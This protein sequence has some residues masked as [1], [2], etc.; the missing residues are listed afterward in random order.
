MEFIIKR[1]TLIS[2]LF[3]AITML[4]Y[5]SYQQL[6]MELMPVP[7][8][9][10]L[11]ITVT[12]NNV[13]LDPEYIESQAIIPIEGAIGTLENIE[14]IN[15]S[16]SKRNSSI[17]ISYKAGTDMNLAYLK[18]EQEMNDTRSSLPDEFNVIVSKSN[19]TSLSNMFMN[20]LI[21]G[22]GDEDQIRNITD[23]DI[24]PELE[25][26]DGIASVNVFGGSSKSVEIV[27]DPD[28]AE[29]YQLTPNRIINKLRSGQLDRVS[30]GEA[31]KG[32]TR[33][34]VNVSSEFTEISNI[35]DIVIS[36]EGPVLLKDI[37]EISF[38]TKDPTSY[39]RVNGKESITIIL[40]NDTEVNE[41]DLSHRTREAIEKINAENAERG[42]EVI[43]QSD[44]AETM[45]NNINQIIELAVIGGIL[46]IIILWYFLQNLTLVL[47]VS[48]AI[49][50]S[51]YAA[52]NMF[53]AFGITINSLSLVGMALA[54]GMLIDNS[55]VVL[56]NIYR[57]VSTGKSIKDSVL[58]GVQEVWKSIFA[59]TLTTVAVFVPF[60]YSENIVTRL[61]SKQ[62]GVSIISTLLFSLLAA[63]LLIPMMTSVILNRTKSNEIKGFQ[64][65]SIRSR[66][67][68]IYLL[69]LKS[70]MRKPAQ[71]IIGA[72][73][74]FFITL[75]LCLTNTTNALQEV[76]TDQIDL[77]VTMPTGSTLDKCDEL[78]VQLEE[79]L[80][81]IEEKETVTSKVEEET[82][83]LSLK[84]AEN[85]ESIAD[86][87]MTD[88]RQQMKS[89][90][91]QYKDAA[92]IDFEASESSDR[93][94][95]GGGGQAN[96]S[97][98][99]ERMLGMG[100]SEER[101][102]I[103]GDDYYLL[104]QVCEDLEYYLEEMDEISRVRSDMSSNQPE[105]HLDFSGEML[106]K[107][108]IT[109][110]SISSEL[111]SFDKEIESGFNFKT[112]NEEYE[113][114]IRMDTVTE[115]D[116]N[117]M[118][119]LQK[120][121]VENTESATYELQSISSIFK[122]SGISRI[123]RTNLQ[124][125][126]EIT[127][128]FSDDINDS[129]ELLE[130]S[131]LAI[132]ELV[133]SLPLPSGVAVEVIHEEDDFD[134][135]K[136]IALIAILLIF[137]IL[138]SVF[139]SFSTPFVLMF[140]IPLAGIG[141][142]LALYLTDNSLI[143]ANTL[144]GFIILIGVVINNGIILIDYTNILQKRGYREQRALMMA[145]IARLRPI[146]ITALT[147]ITAMLPLAMGENEYV[148]A[149]GAPFAITVIGGLAVSTLL[150][151]VFVPTLYSALNASL[152][153]FKA[154]PLWIRI[155]QFAIYIA[156]IW[157]IYTQVNSI[158]WQMIDGIALIILVPAIVWFIRNSLRKASDDVIDKKEEITITVQ[159]LV[160]IYGRQGRFRREWN[161]GIALRERF[162]IAKKYNS[163]KDLDELAWIIPLMIFSGYLAFI[164]FEK[165]FW[166]F[167]LAC[168][169]YGL[170]NKIFRIFKSLETSRKAQ[171]KGRTF[172]KLVHIKA[173]TWHWFAPLAG[174]IVLYTK[175]ENIGGSIV[176]FILVYLALVIDHASNKINKEGINVN[177]LEGKFKNTR[178]VFYRFVLSIPILGKK[179]KPFKALKGVS[180]T[181][182]NG[183]YGLLGPN[184]AG[185]S[186]LMRTICGIYDQSYG[187]IF[188]NGIDTN[189]KREELQGIIGYL[190]QEF[191]MYENMT[192][193]DYLD[194]QAMIKNISHRKT[195]ETR[196][197]NV[198]RSV[199]MWENRDKKI[200][201]FS[202]GMKQRVGIAQVL[203]H[204]PRVLV[205]DE[206]T[207]G[208][209][210]RERIRFRNLLIELS[211]TRIVIFSTHII[212]DISSS[213][214]QLAVLKQGE[215]QY[216][217]SPRDMAQKA[218]GHVWQVD[219]PVHEFEKRSAQYKA[220]HHL[221]EGDII[222]MR[223]LSEEKPT[224][225]A[226]AV[227]PNLEDAYL[228]L[229]KRNISKGNVSAD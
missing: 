141:S 199:H 135:Y 174:I 183:M 161:G 65:L 208:L 101:I 218:Q 160:K 77:Y 99:M 34:F 115:L 91:K 69:L 37:S 51:V 197:E 14:E 200:G 167:L 220:I 113:I 97:A 179:S 86:R 62:I 59:A 122:S 20:L 79:E 103:K 64:S 85:Y 133:Q 75:G 206:P 188:F 53:Y 155:T 171:G 178:K 147:T 40:V 81:K 16:I 95:G 223:V 225:E 129:P 168:A 23:E 152:R 33:Y 201:S 84:L 177:R 207:A 145:G 176:L 4:G 36:T 202:G 126:L 157:A 71:T 87:S 191:G 121:E 213:C 100:T 159:N 219:V 123:Q 158:I 94:G 63:V 180:L 222:R 67:V 52:F 1:K 119:D 106:S 164:Y 203:L 45:E 7:E 192:A 102:E 105:V 104:A 24:L 68:Q 140:S 142:L 43:V 80:M 228:W 128:R 144:I 216:V 2:M 139:E 205:V 210:P 172:E 48:L 214:N 229:Q 187:K 211:R 194:Y 204:L 150:T 134:E 146:L 55:V 15:S 116:P 117:S 111:K 5:I 212:E 6:E 42:I 96:K 46:A 92:D 28:L 74:V 169:V 76:Q 221:R 127:Y 41:I 50:I 184:G 226:I 60:L 185:K 56:E 19:T 148:G 27:I 88:I 173:L 195:R 58:K 109:L 66:F 72:L 11:N 3:I 35:E 189:L 170:G 130:S 8:M 21:L 38:S 131:R 83:I 156:G 44:M 132:D 196:V 25:N 137:M 118:I 217:G 26:I 154:L 32:S 90:I 73:V 98:Q 31:Y 78:V 10:E 29:A 93:F 114:I 82:A 12:T 13:E 227:E 47:S 224:Q 57:L 110:Q 89:I 190:P 9:P 215:V 138:A 124:K 70:A 198:L 166:Q 49:P 143:N 112:D 30:V 54:I 163:Y 107:N 125:Q 61:L 108:N 18:L 175:N 22:P 209:D 149:I 151:L 136:T 193:W 182:E 153:W 162:N 186:T 17:T 120:L 165:S 181:I 39:S